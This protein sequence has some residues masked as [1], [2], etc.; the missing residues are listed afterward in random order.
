MNMRTAAPGLYSFGY[1]LVSTSNDGGL[2][3]TKPVVDKNLPCPACQASIIR[4]NEKEILFLNP[5]V[6]WKGGFKLRSRHNLTL[7]L[8]QDDG[9][10]WKHSRVLN[11]TLAGY[12]DMAI[13]KDGK[14]ICV[15]EN[16]IKD[17]CEKL[18]VVQLDR[19]W[20]AAEN[21]AQQGVEPRE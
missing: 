11:E 17:Y 20:I 13:T 2:T 21:A 6:H 16:G 1:K 3:W 4:L 7:R 19:S 14:I 12:S 8:S 18:T 5:A 10:T 15:Y 9:R